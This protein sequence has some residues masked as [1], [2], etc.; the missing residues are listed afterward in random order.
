MDRG[1]AKYYDLIRIQ[2]LTRVSLTLYRF[3]KVA[4]LPGSHIATDIADRVHQ[5][6]VDIGKHILGEILA[7]WQAHENRQFET[8]ISRPRQFSEKLR[9]V[10]NYGPTVLDKY[11]YFY[12]L[13]D[14]ASQL[15]AILDP[16]SHSP[17]FAKRVGSIIK[18]SKEDSFRW[19]AVRRFLS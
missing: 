11:H 17:E 1:D 14:C 6:Y 12:G 8:Y 13:L 10:F 19:K 2:T 4:S 7:I 18:T 15:S 5:S 16:D 3:L 9:A